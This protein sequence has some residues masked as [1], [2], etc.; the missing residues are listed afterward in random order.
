MLIQYPVVK[1]ADVCVGE[2]IPDQQYVS[3]GISF[4]KVECL[5][6]SLTIKE[7]SIFGKLRSQR[8][9]SLVSYPFLK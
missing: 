5:M 2:G 4:N 6:L 9:N 3:V 7:S 1:V 8:I